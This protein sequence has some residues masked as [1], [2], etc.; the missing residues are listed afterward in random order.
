MDLSWKIAAGLA[1]L[2]AWIVAPSPVHAAPRCEQDFLYVGDNADGQ[3]VRI[4]PVT[5]ESSLF[6]DDGELD[7]PRGMIFV[8]EGA[9][10]YF[11]VVDQNAGQPVT[12]EVLRYDAVT[13]EF[14]DALVPA[15]APG[16]SPAPF[17]PR[18]MVLGK[19]HILYV[20]DLGQPGVD[21]L[22]GRV[23]MFD[24]RT[25]EYLGDLET[26]DFDGVFRPR[27]IV[28]GP[29]GDLYVTVT[30]LGDPTAPASGNVGGYV[31]R[32]EQKTGEFLGV[33][34]DSETCGCDLNRPEG[35]V[36]GP[37]GLLYVTSFQDPTNP[38]SVDQILI[39]EE[40]DGQWEAI[41]SIPL[42]TA[43]EPRV[44]AQALLFGPGG[45]LYVP[46]SGP[47]ASPESGTVRV[48]DVSDID[49]PVLVDTLSPEALDQGWYLTFERTDPGTLEYDEPNKI[50]LL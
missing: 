34:I 9:D 39:F 14:I 16:T 24:V 6:V 27:G 42:W 22:P 36:F 26:P 7:S 19:H 2:A 44:F 1:C 45:E 49:D 46:I 10:E 17:L 33:V 29:D 12:G 25:G 11:L 13:G 20:V 3:I 38:M 41:G 37:D 47:A 31:L 35:L 30:N 8:R 28:I 48:Y 4:D 18:G 43:P 40:T 32:F 23:A 21:A 5:G 15:T 50:C